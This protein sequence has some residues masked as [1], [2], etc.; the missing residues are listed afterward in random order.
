MQ[1]EAYRLAESWW[2]QDLPFMNDRPIVYGEIGVYHGHNLVSAEKAFAH[3]PQSIL[4]AID[5]WM[6]Y[7]EY[8]EY[9]G[10]QQ[11][12]YEYAMNNIKYAKIESKVRVIRKK[13]EEAL[14]EFSDNYFDILYIDGSH[15][16][17]YVVKDC[18]LSKSKVKRGGYL[19]ID[20]TNHPPIIKAVDEVIGASNEY[21]LVKDKTDQRIYRRV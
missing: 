13:S 10:K 18:E 21:V 15:V 8:P 19:I 1:G 7:D 17:E 2:N 3:H 4:Y 6:D 16:Y 9:K 11:T 20:D 14:L 5:P 12:N